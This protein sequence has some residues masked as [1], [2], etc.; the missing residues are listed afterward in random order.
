MQNEIKWSDSCEEHKKECSYYCITDHSWLCDTCYASHVKSHSIV[1][2]YHLLQ[3][4]TIMSKMDLDNTYKKQIESLQK[5]MNEIMARAFKYID[6]RVHESYK[7]IITNINN[8]KLVN[9][10]E[11]LMVLLSLC[12]KNLTEINGIKEGESITLGDKKSE[13]VE[14]ISA[15]VVNHLNVKYV[16]KKNKPKL[17]PRL[18]QSTA[19]TSDPIYQSRRSIQQASSEYIKQPDT[20]ELISRP[21]ADKK[22][23]LVTKVPINK[24]EDTPL[25][26]TVIE[27]KNNEQTENSKIE[28][29]APTVNA[30]EQYQTNENKDKI[31][32]NDEANLKEYQ[33]DHHED[34]KKD[35][36]SEV[37]NL[38]VSSPIKSSSFKIR[39]KIIN[40]FNKKTL[41]L[42]S[43]DL[44]DDGVMQLC[45]YLES[46]TVLQTIS[47]WSNKI[48]DVGAGYLANMLKKNQTIKA[49]NLCNVIP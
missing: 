49:L 5:D 37:N 16:Q 14:L 31:I 33:S 34:V 48:T 41:D 18:I 40:I 42:S 10:V 43:Q 3:M 45:Q 27:E 12:C 4:A 13:F 39:G 44:G 17:D 25:Q 6:T 28:A 15:S 19:P 1:P 7:I 20:N 24:D 46:N 22:I 32:I 29:Q 30:I 38:F 21:D 11:D 36:V 23:L 8:L 47:L 26:T 2:F 35:M 9:R